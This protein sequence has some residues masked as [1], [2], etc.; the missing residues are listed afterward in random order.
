MLSHFTGQDTKAQEEEKQLD[1]DWR[2]ETAKPKSWS[3]RGHVL[4][5][6]DIFRLVPNIQLSNIMLSI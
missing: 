6:Y 2:L 1:G 5:H 3:L 4:S